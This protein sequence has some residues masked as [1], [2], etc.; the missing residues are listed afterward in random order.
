MTFIFLFTV[1]N[2]SLLCWLGTERRGSGFSSSDVE[3]QR[4][5]RHPDS[6]PFLLGKGRKRF[7][8]PPSRSSWI[9]TE[10]NGCP[11]WPSWC[12]WQDP[13]AACTSSLVLAAQLLGP[14]SLKWISAVQEPCW[15]SVPCFYGPKS[16]LYLW[17]HQVLTRRRL[18]YQESPKSY[19]RLL[20][21]CSSSDA[22]AHPTATT[23]SAW[24]VYMVLDLWKS[25]LPPP[26]TT[27]MKASEPINRA[28]LRT[29]LLKTSLLCIVVTNML[30]ICWMYMNI[31]SYFC[32]SKMSEV[33]FL[34]HLCWT[35][36][37][38]KKKKKSPDSSC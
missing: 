33:F 2:Q 14:L 1:R 29:T 4:D 37:G 35:K 20:W 34:S 23:H 16:P 36:K 28:I 21:T 24:S 5:I 6:Q 30:S 18:T 3:N 31:L 8:T 11:A 27:Q 38:F 22:P 10:E 15:G 17:G 12:R 7:L 13:H 25:R 32:S 26:A 19:C 9:C